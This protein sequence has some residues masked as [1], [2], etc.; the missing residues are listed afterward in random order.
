MAKDKMIDKYRIKKVI[1]EGG[2]GKVYLAVHPTL[3]K[4]IIIKRLSISSKKSLSDRFRREARVM[5][6]FRHENIVSVY[7]HF[8]HGQSYYIAMEFID[9]ISLEDLI[10]KKKKISP[11]AAILILREIC[12]GLQYA[13]SKG[14]IHRDIKPDNVL[15]SNAGEVKLFDFGIAMVETEEEEEL[16]KTGIVMGTP[17]YMSPEQIKD[18]KHVDKRSD[19]YSLG[20]LFYQMITGKKAFPGGFSAD[21]IHR[22]TRGIYPRPQK[23][24]GKIPGFFKTIIKKTMNH[25][26]GRRYKDL[27][28]LTHKLDN[29]LFKFKNQ[30][31][32]HAGLKKYLREDPLKPGQFEKVPRK[33]KRPIVK[34]AIAAAV[35]VI[36]F[37]GVVFLGD[38]LTE[39]FYSFIFGRSV[40]ALEVRVIIPKDYY[41]NPL[42]VFTEMKL[43]YNNPKAEKKE[44]RQKTQSYNLSH[45]VV[46]IPFMNGSG[47]D[48]EEQ[49]ALSSG[50][51]FL[52]EGK[53]DL[54]LT[55][56]DKKYLNA[57]TLAPIVIQKQNPD[58]PDKRKVI[59]IKYPVDP[60]RKIPVTHRVVDRTTKRSLNA[61]VKIF[62]K[63]YGSWVDWKYAEGQLPVNLDCQFR[64]VVDG[65]FTR[66]ISVYIN[67]ELESL[68]AYAE[69]MRKP[70]KLILNSSHDG[71]QIFIDN[72][73]SDFI[74]P[75]DKAFVVFGNT[76]K[77]GKTFTLES[78]EYILTIKR[79]DE[80]T[81]NKTFWIQAEKDTRISVEYDEGKKQ[82]R[83]VQ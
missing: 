52:P 55:V 71:L 79:D 14:V 54:S 62:Y 45:R 68:T 2:M 40:G 73:A 76:E 49:S 51:L 37:T 69:L 28:T 42:I 36:V 18:A 32:V 3:K 20:A 39:I 5:M 21:T 74:G 63:P 19:I 8:K 22:I 16:T 38:Q 67:R 25:K 65:Y 23:Y 7:D 59:E 44:D 60:Y 46:R 24:T 41:K 13:H 17:S 11:L 56:E 77:K 4:D 78:G 47:A 9:G 50:V 58:Y 81:S 15:L 33:K 34:L 48:A 70:G 83:I 10:E 26:I 57:F 12:R 66:E 31:Q 27:E 72:K 82:I 75:E 43:T 1:G 30:D 29:Y 35:F 6:G 61:D 64:Y 80:T 53:Y